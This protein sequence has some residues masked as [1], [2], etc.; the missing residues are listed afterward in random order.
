MFTE[1]AHCSHSV[2]GKSAIFVRMEKRLQKLRETLKFE[3]GEL[4]HHLDLS[5]SMLD[6]VR[7]GKRHLGMKAMRRLEQ[8]EGAAGIIPHSAPSA[9]SAVNPPG[10]QRLEKSA[11]KLPTPGNALAARFQR[12]E[13]LVAA[14]VKELAELKRE[15][16]EEK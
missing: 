2:K 14:V 11:E 1:I 10:F 7:K 8:A 9:A 4:A 6:Q 16:G 12:L 5:R 15:M 3:W 13:K